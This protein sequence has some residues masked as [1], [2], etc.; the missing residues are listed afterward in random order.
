M[1]S[2]EPEESMTHVPQ[3]GIPLAIA[4]VDTVYVSVATQGNQGPTRLSAAWRS[5]SGEILEQS[6]AQV[7][8]GENTAFQLS[9]PNGLGP[10]T[11]KMVLSLGGDCADTKVFVVGK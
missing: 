3:V 5:R 4:A 9:R 10:G 2:L 1:V 8:V 7:R 6:T 11:S